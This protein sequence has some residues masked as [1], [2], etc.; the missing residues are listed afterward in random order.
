MGWPTD[1][2]ILSERDQTNGT[3]EHALREARPY[4]TA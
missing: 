1:R 2:P 3:L 4:A